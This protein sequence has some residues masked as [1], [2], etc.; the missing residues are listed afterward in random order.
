MKWS[1][2]TSF[3]IHG[4]VGFYKVTRKDFLLKNFGIAVMIV[5]CKFFTY[6]CK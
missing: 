2:K 4:K 6:D 3:R 5:V 1:N